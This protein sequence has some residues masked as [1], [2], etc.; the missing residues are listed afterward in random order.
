MWKEEYA[1]ISHTLGKGTKDKGTV[2]LGCVCDLEVLICKKG[3]A[4]ALLLFTLLRKSSS[5]K[6]F[7]TTDNSS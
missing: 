4:I 7:I 1:N 6:D 3:C 5:S 2:F